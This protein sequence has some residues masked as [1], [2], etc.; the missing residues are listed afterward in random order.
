MRLLHTFTVAETPHRC[1][2]AADLIVEP[3]CYKERKKALPLL[4]R[5]FPFLPETDKPLSW[6]TRGGRA[7]TTPET[8]RH[9]KTTE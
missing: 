2:E 7:R 8:P 4:R 5:L 6:P 3:D 9:L 1:P